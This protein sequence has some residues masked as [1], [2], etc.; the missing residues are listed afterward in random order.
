LAITAVQFW[1]GLQESQFGIR[2]V[3]G[4]DF[5][6]SFSFPP[7]NVITLIAP[8]FFGT[9]QGVPYWGAGIYW[10]MSLFFGSAVL[11]L[12]IMG[13]FEGRP[14]HRRHAAIM[15]GILFVLAL[16]AN[17]PAFG[18]LYDFLPGFKRFRGTSKFIMMLAPFMALL[19]AAGLQRLMQR[20]T[21]RHRW[22][23]GLFG[24]GAI[25][26]VAVALWPHV[27]SQ[28]QGYERW[29][30]WMKAIYV[31]GL[32]RHESRLPAVAYEDPVFIADTFQVSRRALFETGGTL[33]VLAASLAFASRRKLAALPAAIIALVELYRFASPLRMTFPLEHVELP[34][35]QAQLASHPGSG[36]ILNKAMPN[37]GMTT[38][39]LDIGG[40]D[41]G[42][43]QRYGEFL[44]FAQYG[45]L[46]SLSHGPAIESRKQLALLR[47][48]HLVELEGEELVLVPADEPPLP[49]IFFA[50]TY[51][52]F[53]ERYAMLPLLFSD[54]F[55]P[56]HT[57]LLE[58]EPTPRPSP[59]DSAAFAEVIEESTDH[60]V[61]HARVNEPALMVVT[62]A[63][64]PFWRAR[65]IK[66]GAQSDYEVIPADYVLRAIALE[67]G[68]HWIKLEYRIPGW[69]LAS[70]VSI[71]SLAAFLVA[72]GRARE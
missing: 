72:V 2:M 37:S 47:L 19:A 43:T 60:L 55:D 63:Y 35:L 29:T 48:E 34:A 52:A 64:H 24:A 41:P 68:E 67:R 56:R 8:D 62:D 38:G 7:E 59:P 51:E 46:R 44:C 58:S 12:A 65:P 49:R 11:L 57:V 6:S 15:I 14:E 69:N 25:V 5:A 22:I 61:I 20:G 50:Q 70:A 54:G 10:E 31:R 66:R 33:V 39:A 32:P 13:A 30:R 26:L 16:G 9:I 18:A 45:D 53:P 1:A 40:Y 27:T 4:R 28:D 36:R 23:F 17:G 3:A 71:V 42:I 21:L